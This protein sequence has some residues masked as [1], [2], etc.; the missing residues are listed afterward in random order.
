MARD[1]EGL[2]DA[3][4]EAI[5][6]GGSSQPP[7]QSKFESMSDEELSKIA[8]EADQ[9]Q[10]DQ[11]W[12]GDIAAGLR[13]VRAAIPGARH[14]AAGVESFRKGVPYQEELEHQKARDEAL[15]KEHPKS[16]F[17][18]EV[19]GTF[20]PIGLPGGSIAGAAMKGE[21]AIAGRL[22]PY[23][24][25]GASNVAG[26]ALTGAALGAAQGAGEATDVESAIENAKSGAKWGAG[27]GTVAPVVGKALGL[28]SPLRSTDVEQAAKNLKSNIRTVKPD[29]DISIP[30]S[31]AS[32]SGAVRG[33]TNFLSGFPLTKTMMDRA[34][35]KGLSSLEEAL[36]N[37]PGIT[38]A[39]T[40]G[41]VPA[42]KGAKDSLT[43]WIIKQSPVEV[44]T[45]YNN[46]NTIFAPHANKPVKFA[47]LAKKASALNTTSQ[48]TNAVNNKAADFVE[49]AL[50]GLTPKGYLNY[51]DAMN[52]RSK[53]GDIAGDFTTTSS[54]DRKDYANLA[55]ALKE[56]LETHFTTHGGT[57]AKD[58]Y[59]KAVGE[60]NK[61]IN[62]KKDFNAIINK[63]FSAPDA[64]VYKRISALAGTGAKENAPLLEKARD[65]MHPAAWQQIQ[66][67]TVENMG[68][69]KITGQ[70]F[71]VNEYL[72]NFNK[73]SDE[74]KDAI[75]GQIGAPTR[76]ALED[77]NKIAQRYKEV[78]KEQNFTN[79]WLA[80][81]GL[82]GTAAVATQG[83]QGLEEEAGIAAG[84][85]LLAAM[86]TRPRYASMAVDY[87]AAKT[88]QAAKSILDRISREM[89][90]VSKAV[91]TKSLAPK[92][93][94][95]TMPVTADDREERASGGSVNKRDYPAKRLSRME[96]AIKRAQDAI[97]LESK[98]IMNQPDHVVARALEIAKDK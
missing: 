76:N 62:M 95:T 48:A 49:A 45:H 53:L 26:S 59:T 28:S 34:T 9:P 11:G 60:A 32:D 98:P 77:I 72:K 74:G 97:A 68:K 70:A 92:F 24:G 29:Y 96:K 14:V 80:I 79:K 83:L 87:F 16:Y 40:T 8:G 30:A 17:G 44:S 39:G 89:G 20:L 43:D 64:Q 31:I 41:Y 5:V 52:L 78:G 38:G 36:E 54:S 47:E 25:K 86:L 93:N 27:L 56:D 42:G 37:I 73:M 51:K 67:A 85:V 18:G 90:T 23:I 15:Q 82:L 94:V 33:A 81:T 22:A 2:S 10:T 69:N 66:A 1:L 65:V 21:Q 6:G 3:E 19:A 46:L 84:S 13:G 55:K 4:L 71:D 50:Q 88:P 61:I 91:T 75:F 58:A 12:R 7:A 57:P 35:G 63:D